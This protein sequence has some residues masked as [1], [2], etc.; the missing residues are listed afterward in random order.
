[1]SA[2]TAAVARGVS[3][4]RATLT[5]GV[6]AAVLSLA[7][8]GPETW[9]LNRDIAL[10]AQPWRLLTAHLTHSDPEHLAWNLI[11]LAALGTAFEPILRWRL[12]A[13]LATAVLFIDIWFYLADPG[14]TRY[15]GLS[16][17]LN[18]LLIAGLLEWYRR[19]GEQMPILIGIGALAKTLFELFSDVAVFTN[20]AW[21]P[22]PEAHLL[23]ISA[24]IIWARQRFD[25]GQH[26]GASHRR[27]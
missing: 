21:Q 26:A 5:L 22:A 23:G 6:L 8:P 11:G 12:P 15:C 20:L 4:S 14:L 10:T 25:P 7:P 1:M 9:F 2:L 24:G 27:D 18:G 17:L 3:T 16:G 13:V 19:S